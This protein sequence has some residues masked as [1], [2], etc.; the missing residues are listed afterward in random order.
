VA[1]DPH[2]LMRA[3]EMQSILDCADLAAAASLYRTE[4]RWGLYHLRV[5]YPET[6]NENWFCHTM[7]YKDQRGRIAHRKR[8]IDPY[9]VPVAADEMS[10]YH[11]LRIK[12]PVAAE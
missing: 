8:P 6:D 3:L 7:H 10:A 5:D 11:H 4:S 1:R 2:E 9:I 12:T